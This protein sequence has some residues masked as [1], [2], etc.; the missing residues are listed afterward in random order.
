MKRIFA[1][2]LYAFSISF[3]VQAQSKFFAFIDSLLLQK[4]IQQSSVLQS[5]VTNA[6]PKTFDSELSE[7]AKAK[8]N[9][10]AYYHLLLTSRG[11]RDAN[12]YGA[13]Q[14]PYFWNYGE[15]NTRDSIY[16]TEQNKPLRKLPPPKGFEKYQSYASVDRTPVLFWTDAAFDH[17]KYQYM[18]TKFYSFGWCSEREMAFKAWLN[19]QGI[20]STI[21]FSGIHVW[22]EVEL[23]ELPDYYIKADNTFNEFTLLPKKDMPKRDANDKYLNWYNLQGAGV[24]VKNQ[25]RL[26]TVSTHRAKEIEDAVKLFFTRN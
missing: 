20:K 23:P 4:E 19:L 7:A 26:L 14:L 12:T 16:S 22:N 5:T 8:I 3:S 6:L 9:R 2:I 25:L 17:A 13:L 10:V 1:F 15:E 11:A 21:C 24:T 18:G